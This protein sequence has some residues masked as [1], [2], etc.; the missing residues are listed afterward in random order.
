[1]PEIESVDFTGKDRRRNGRLK[2]ATRDWIYLI[3]LA[4]TII[5]AW[6]NLKWTVD[7][8]AK[9]LTKYAPLVDTHEIKIA[10]IEN[11]IGNIEKN[12]NEI[13]NVLVNKKE[14]WEQRVDR[15]AMSKVQ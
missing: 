14:T 9:Q 13:K 15:N 2:L 7:A 5:L 8:N 4:V 3:G 1:M 11:S 12:I 10:V 6:G